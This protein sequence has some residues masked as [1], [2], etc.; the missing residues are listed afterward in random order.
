[1]CKRYCKN[2]YYIH[3]YIYFLSGFTTSKV[4][5]LL[6]CFQ[7]Q[8]KEGGND[9]KHIGEPIGKSPKTKGAYWVKRTHSVGYEFQVCTGSREVASELSHEQTSEKNIEIEEPKCKSYDLKT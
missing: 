8:E 5:Q 6:Q 9:E 4:E 2:V 3:K 7:L 1:M